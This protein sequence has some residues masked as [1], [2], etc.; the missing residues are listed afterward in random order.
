MD[1]QP[2]G[3]GIDKR[4]PQVIYVPQDLRMDLLS[5]RITW[6]QGGIDPIHPAATGQDLYATQRL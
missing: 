5:Q 4:F 1:L 3:Y 2:E 6:D